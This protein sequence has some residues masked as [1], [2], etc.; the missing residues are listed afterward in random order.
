MS[1]PS[2]A[3]LCAA[4]VPPDAHRSRS[5]RRISALTAALQAALGICAALAGRGRTGRGERVGARLANGPVSTL[6]YLAAEALESGRQPARTGND[7]PIL[8]PYGL[9]RTSDGE[10]AIAP[11]NQTIYRKFI[12]AIGAPEIL[13][14][15][16][17]A[18][19]ALRVANRAAINRAIEAKLAGGTTDQSIETLNAPGVPCGRVL[20]LAEMFADPQ[21]RAQEMVV[22]IDHPGHGPVEMLGFPIKF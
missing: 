9:F 6:A 2:R 13:G 17:F 18:T 3:T 7:H 14:D 5:A 11:A 19:N 8:S 4:N 16:A 22:T 20:A 21:I 15:P 1:R 10:V 12:A